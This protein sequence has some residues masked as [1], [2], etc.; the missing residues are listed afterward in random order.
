M[1]NLIL[2]AWTFI[3]TATFSQAA[4][5]LYTPKQALADAL[6]EPLVFVGKF[7]PNSSESGLYPDCV[8]KNSKVMVI[9]SYCVQ[10]AVPAARVMVV[11]TLEI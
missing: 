5:A 2:S 1:K 4:S 8:F 9:S 3:L 10:K 11:Y 7:I 6:S